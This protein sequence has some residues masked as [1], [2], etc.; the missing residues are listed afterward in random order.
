M[1]VRGVVWCG[2]RMAAGRR[3]AT[4]QRRGL[5]NNYYV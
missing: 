5:Y 1:V 4:V 2:V 3:G